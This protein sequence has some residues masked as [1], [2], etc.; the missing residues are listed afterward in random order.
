MS[1]D[2]TTASTAAETTTPALVSSV[3]RNVQA[4]AAN[5]G[6]WPDAVKQEVA[7]LMLATGNIQ[8]V[9]ATT[10]VSR[11]VISA[12]KK[13][14]WWKELIDS[15]RYDQGLEVDANMTRIVNSALVAVEDRLENGDMVLNNKTGQIVRKPVSM[16]DASLVARDLLVRQGAIRKDT[17]E[18]SQQKETVKE[19]LMLL[20]KEFA[21]WAKKPGAGDDIVDV[22][23]KEIS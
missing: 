10:G 6:R 21:K 9:S 15:F 2:T 20:A 22:E 1:E 8:L 17:G 3:T 12:W 4:Q 13:T 7:K 5:G 14:E 18:V 19:T 23:A 11:D 16:K